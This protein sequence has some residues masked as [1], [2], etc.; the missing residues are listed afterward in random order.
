MG[1]EV[2]T[3]EDL[4]KFRLQ[5]ISEIK[6][7]LLAKPAKKWLKT[8]EVME[9]LDISEV[10]LQ[11]LRNRGKIPFR[12]LGGVCYYNAEEIDE[13]LVTLTQKTKAKAHKGQ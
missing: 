6:E 2:L 5:L 10:T 4:E 12:K 8:A 3:T 11:T 13:L 9:M 7:L 1:L